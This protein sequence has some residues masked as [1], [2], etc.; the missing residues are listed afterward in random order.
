MTS[1]EIV[2]QQWSFPSDPSRYMMF[3]SAEWCKPCQRIKPHVQQLQAVGQIVLEDTITMDVK[4]VNHGRVI[5]SFD[6]VST[7]GDKIIGSIQTSNPA[8][9]DVFLDFDVTN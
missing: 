8:E 6:L 4:D 9:L 2:V 3:Y 5:P 1:K 7:S